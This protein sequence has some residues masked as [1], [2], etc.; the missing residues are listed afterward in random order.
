M[1]KVPVDSPLINTFAVLEEAVAVTT[2]P[3]VNAP[4]VIAGAAVVPT[5]LLSAFATY[6]PQTS[7]EVSPK[8]P[9]LNRTAL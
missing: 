8:T 2:T 1:V 6:R 4:R 9:A 3:L 5:L 7:A